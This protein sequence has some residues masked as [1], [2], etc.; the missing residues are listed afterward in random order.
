MYRG[1][2]FAAA[3]RVGVRLQPA[4]KKNNKING[5]TNGGNVVCVWVV[6]ERS[7]SP[8]CSYCGTAFSPKIIQYRHSSPLFFSSD[9]R[10]GKLET[11]KYHKVEVSSTLTYTRYLPNPS[12]A[13]VLKPRA[14]PRSLGR[15]L[16]KKMC[17]FTL[18]AYV[19]RHAILSGMLV[20][21]R[22]IAGRL[23]N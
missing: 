12:D 17:L 22:P 5:R 6:G 11:K 8:R 10:W 23:C 15:D 18:D 13:Y 3:S 19:L 2:P 4:T 20:R 16:H 1:A 14:I 7:R 9:T 21:R